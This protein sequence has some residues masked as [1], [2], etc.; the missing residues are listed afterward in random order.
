MSMVNI[1]VRRQ[2][3]KISC[4]VGEEAA[5]RHAAVTVEKKIE[6]AREQSGI[7][8]GERTAIMAALMLAYEN[9]KNANAEAKSA[10][11]GDGDKKLIDKMN[12]KLE[13]ALLRTEPP[14]GRVRDNLSQ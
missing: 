5:M 12:S 3:F 9:D 6:E 11:I 13:A 7:V 4:A 10:A 1:K 14:Q 8:D 2:S